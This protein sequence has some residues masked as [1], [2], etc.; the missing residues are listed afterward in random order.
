MRVAKVWRSW[1]LTK[2]SRILMGKKKLETAGARRKCGNGRG[3][4]Y[5]R[6][7]KARLYTVNL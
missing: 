3:F 6:N 7:I 1:R 2:V 4:V 5:Y